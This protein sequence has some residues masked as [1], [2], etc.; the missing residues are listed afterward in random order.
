MTI[1]VSV[2]IPCYKQ[3]QYLREA[4]ESVVA[5]T[6]TDWEIVIVVGSEDDFFK[7][8][9]MQKEFSDRHINVTT[10]GG[11]GLANARNIGI[12][13]T[14]GEYILP[15]DADDKLD[16]LYLERV[17]GAIDKIAPYAIAGT[18]LQE[19]GDRQNTWDL[20]SYSATTIRN[21]NALCNTS[22]FTKQLWKD[23]GGYGIEVMH[24]DWN[25]WI[26]CSEWL[27]QVSLISDRLFLYR[28]HQDSELQRVQPYLTYLDA[29]TK[30][31]ARHLYSE[32]EVQSL[33]TAWASAPDEILM[34]VKA[35]LKQ[36]PNSVRI[37]AQ[38]DAI[39]EYRR[40]NVIL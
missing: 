9:D 1:A 21:R 7:A 14:F 10:D 16:P 13:R 2:V 38:R 20:P 19:F 6:F 34:K 22:L 12:E 35:R 8:V 4:V 25:F 30:L 5:Q 23:V 11:K 17:Y 37:R 15:L 29:A 33:E 27:P 32:T 40:K 28:I 36:F 39:L 24:E 31:A 18:N 26:K 3:E